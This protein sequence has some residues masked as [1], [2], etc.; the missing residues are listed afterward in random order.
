MMDTQYDAF[1]EVYEV[2]FDDTLYDSWYDFT[3]AN[4]E[5]YQVVQNDQQV[6]KL[7]DIGC[8]SGD[9]AILLSR[10]T[11]LSVSGYDLAAKMVE[12][13][14]DKAVTNQVDV[15]FFEGDMLE[16]QEEN[17]YDV[18]TL[19][20]DTLCY[21]DSELAIKKVFDNVYASLKQNGIFMFDIH[22]DYKM[23]ELYP[24]YT[25]VQEWDDALFSWNSEQVRGENTIDHMLNIFI[26]SD[27]NDLY[28]RF[29]ELHQEQVFSLSVYEQLLTKAGFENIKIVAD[30]STEKIPDDK[31]ER[32]FFVGQKV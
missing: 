29:E 17:A 26:K 24:G 23:N 21:L 10:M 7:L 14:R 3:L 4:L 6:I 11:H 22:S 8:G 30:F 2:L 13:A 32:I 31:S 25:F 27:N 18:M 5:N 28:E 15:H 20:C 16:Y 19:F 12:Q 1:A 9:L